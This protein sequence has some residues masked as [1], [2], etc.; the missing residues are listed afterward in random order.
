MSADERIAE[1][2]KVA[3]MVR[4]GVEY[5][6]I[7]VPKMVI[8]RIKNGRGE[9]ET[10]KQLESAKVV[11]VVTMPPKLGERIG[12]KGKETAK[13]PE[14]AIEKIPRRIREEEVVLPKPEEWKRKNG[15]EIAKRQGNRE[16]FKIE[17]ANNIL[18]TSN[19]TL[20]EIHTKVPIIY[21]AMMAFGL[22]SIILGAFS[23]A[24]NPVYYYSVMIGG[25]GVVL[26]TLIGI[27]E[28]AYNKKRR[29]K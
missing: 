4:K 10:T 27:L 1:R 15:K 6:E 16:K 28:V 13:R 11:E 24:S 23:V 8:R 19:R 26:V 2:I 3:E 21:Y 17:Y 7:K 14:E 20:T 25:I 9:I 18:N 12:K 29:L 5:E 22:G